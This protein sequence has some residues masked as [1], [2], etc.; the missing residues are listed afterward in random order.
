MHA[1]LAQ[2][3]NGAVIVFAAAAMMLLSSVQVDLWLWGYA[4]SVGITLL[5][6]GSAPEDQGVAG[7]GRGFLSDMF[8]PVGLVS[9]SLEM[10]LVLVFIGFDYC[11]GL[12]LLVR[13]PDTTHIPCAPRWR[14]C[15]SPSSQ[16]SSMLLPPSLFG[17]RRANFTRQQPFL[18]EKLSLLNTIRCCGTDACILRLIAHHRLLHPTLDPRHVLR[19]TA[20]PHRRKPLATAECSET[21]RS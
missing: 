21:R 10:A 5:W 4:V 3:L 17:C 1:P 12:L 14:S 9:T 20:R 2:L 13:N 6:A 18:A 19:D 11:P 15:A 7:S 8:Y 16:P